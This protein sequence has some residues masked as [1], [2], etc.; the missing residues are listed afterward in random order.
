MRAKTELEVA[1]SRLKEIHNLEFE[2][3]ERIGKTSQ[4]VYDKNNQLQLSS[5][6]IQKRIRDLALQIASDP[7]FKDFVLV[8]ILDGGLPFA[9]ALRKELKLLKVRFQYTTIQA[10]SYIGMVS[11]DLTIQSDPKVPL[12]GKKVLFADDVWDTGNTLHQIANRA[13]SQHATEI[14]NAVLVNK[15]QERTFREYITYVG[16][17]VPEDAF[18]VGFGLDYM[19]LLR[20]EDD[21]TAV[22]K[23]S[24]PNTLERQL[25][26]SK[27]EIIKLIDRLKT[28][29]KQEQI[30][31]NPEP[32]TIVY[33]DRFFPMA[34]QTVTQQVNT[35]NSLGNF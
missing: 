26:D 21:I 28:A 22:D 1:E 2:L 7:E 24:L 12:T 25:L 18:I 19:G 16:F 11:G 34:P 6:N 13:L 3:E 5:E 15:E 17:T 10:K 4:A 20:N 33:P 35:A 9:E 27:P 23:M 31:A 30:V 14:R 32:S 29:T 8:A